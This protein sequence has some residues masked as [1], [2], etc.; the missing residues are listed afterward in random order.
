M[1]SY[2]MKKG[3]LSWKKRFFVLEGDV[4]PPRIAYYV[5]QA[6]EKIRGELEIN[7][8]TRVSDLANK[9]NG[10][11]VI[12]S[13]KALVMYADSEDLRAQWK[14]SVSA[15]ISKLN[16]E[17][18]SRDA[19]S[20][21]HIFQCSGNEFE[22]E[23]KYEL[24]KAVGHGAYGVVISVTNKE[25]AGTGDNEQVAVKKIKDAFDDLVDAKR[26]VREIRLLRHFN[27]DNIIR[28][29]DL[30]VPDKVDFDDIYIV[31]DLMETDLHK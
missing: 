16:K 19:R 30:P 26:I 9:T 23:E 28:I 10:F 13:K 11:Q 5:K 17:D 3:G 27:H 12:T 24:I 4:S 6:D 7:S 18:Q 15:V 20:G 8:E 29:V 22:M 21:Y 14:A 1:E 25:Q 2:L 31:T